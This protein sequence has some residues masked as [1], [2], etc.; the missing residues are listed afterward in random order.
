VSST[1]H[2]CEGSAIGKWILRHSESTQMGVPC[3]AL[4]LPSQVLVMHQALDV[5]MTG[6]DM[7]VVVSA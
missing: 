4:R 5:D 2:T 6:A 1:V 3:N 7:L